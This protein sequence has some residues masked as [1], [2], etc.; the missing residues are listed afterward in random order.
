VAGIGKSWT[1][2]GDLEM[3]GEH[4]SGPHGSRFGRE[5]RNSALAEMGGYDGDSAI[6]GCRGAGGIFGLVKG[7]LAT[8]KEI[9]K[10]PEGVN[11]TRIEKEPLDK[12]I[13]TK[14]E[15]TPERAGGNID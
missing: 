2:R 7:E 11:C 8:E 1:Y 9:R 6:E 4:A 5:S 15:F 13:S 3:L 12:I 14:E 10:P